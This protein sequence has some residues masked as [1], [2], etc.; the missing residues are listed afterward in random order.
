[1]RL[2]N[3][4][5]KKFAANTGMTQEKSREAIHALLNALID[6]VDERGSFSISVFGRFKVHYSPGG[7]MKHPRTGK[8]VQQKPN[9]Q[10]GFKASNY[11]KDRIRQSRSKESKE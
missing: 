4:F 2:D 6:E 5:L 8:M 9:V 10:V 7:L 3:K 11:F 1:M